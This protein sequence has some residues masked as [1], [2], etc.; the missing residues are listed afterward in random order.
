[1]TA[2][3]ENCRLLWLG[4]KDKFRLTLPIG[5]QCADYLR[6][7]PSPYARKLVGSASLNSPADYRIPSTPS[8]LQTRSEIS[9]WGK[10]TIRLCESTSPI[11]GSHKKG[12]RPPSAQ[13]GAG[14]AFRT[15]D[16]GARTNTF[17]FLKGQQLYKF[18]PYPPSNGRENAD[19]TNEAG[20]RNS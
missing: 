12:W 17:T 20:P 6:G 19:R 14:F 5:L 15:T 2:P 11:N 16:K 10:V 8:A 18:P 1:M 3:S 4:V 13:R 9:N 7:H